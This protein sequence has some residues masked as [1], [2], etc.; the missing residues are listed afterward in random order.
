MSNFVLD[1]DAVIS[2]LLEGIAN[3]LTIAWTSVKNTV[4]KPFHWN[5]GRAD[6]LAQKNFGEEMSATKSS[7]GYKKY[8]T[9]TASSALL[10]ISM[11]MRLKK[12]KANAELWQV[13][14]P[15]LC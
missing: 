5:A 8:E 6:I 9:I 15:S 7:L 10:T 2:K 12:P 13:T 3:S 1:V 14:V 4:A 11:V